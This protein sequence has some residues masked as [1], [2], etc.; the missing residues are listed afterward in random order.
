MRVERQRGW[1]TQEQSERAMKGGGVSANQQPPPIARLRMDTLNPKT[2]NPK[3][4]T[5]NS[6]LQDEAQDVAKIGLRKL[7]W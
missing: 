4:Y 1:D 7:S 5:L 2:L 6:K 3:P